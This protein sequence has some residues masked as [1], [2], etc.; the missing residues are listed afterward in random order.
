MG[1]YDDNNIAP[2]VLTVTGDIFPCILAPRPP[3]ITKKE[4]VT[5]HV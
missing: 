5:A 1:E 3:H 2:D 4:Y